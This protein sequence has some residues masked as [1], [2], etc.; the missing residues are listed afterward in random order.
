[1]VTLQPPA[2]DA[3]D[4]WGVYMPH[5][6][7]QRREVDQVLQEHFLP[8]KYSIMAGDMN[9]AFINTDRAT[10]TMNAAD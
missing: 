8:D 6:A 2:G 7:A 1:M 3:I 9:A 10:G 4:L 5:D